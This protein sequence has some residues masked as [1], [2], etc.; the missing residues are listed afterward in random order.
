MRA[1]RIGIVAARA[2]IL[3]HHGLPILYPAANDV[4][5]RFRDLMAVNAE[6][7][8]A[9][10]EVRPTLIANAKVDHKMRELRRGSKSGSPA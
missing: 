7:A 8:A 3:G 6:K 1:N 9:A 2:R 4:V 5:R 10:P